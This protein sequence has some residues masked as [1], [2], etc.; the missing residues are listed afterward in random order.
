MQRFRSQVGAVGLT[1]E[2]AEKKGYDVDIGDFPYPINGL[3]MRVSTDDLKQALK[4]F[5][6]FKFSDF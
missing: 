2:E 3:A 4:V 1:E 5:S 6:D